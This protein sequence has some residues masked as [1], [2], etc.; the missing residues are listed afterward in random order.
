MARRP[1]IFT[2]EQVVKLLQVASQL[3]V[4]STSLL[5]APVFRLA[6]VLLY[7]LGLRRSEVVRLVMSDYDPVERTLLVLHP[8][9]ARGPV[10]HRS[11][12]ESISAPSTSVRARLHITRCST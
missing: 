9:V 6:I 5:R 12:V 11:Y 4:R 1:H 7:T 10:T 2:Y 8:P 3:P